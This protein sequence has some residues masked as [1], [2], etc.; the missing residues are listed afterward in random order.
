MKQKKGAEMQ[1]MQFK[2]FREDIYSYEDTKN[3]AVSRVKEGVNA[4]S[5]HSVNEKKERVDPVKITII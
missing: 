5:T 4:L 2:P 1:L 3:I